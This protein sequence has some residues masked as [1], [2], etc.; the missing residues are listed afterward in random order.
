MSREDREPIRGRTDAARALGDWIRDPGTDQHDVD[1]VLAQLTEASH[2]A[3]Q[4]RR[5]Q[6]RD[7]TTS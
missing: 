2:Q 1:A 7:D 6:H 5:R 4:D 3:L